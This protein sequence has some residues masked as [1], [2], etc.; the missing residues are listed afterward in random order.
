MR[1]A[2]IFGLVLAGCTGEKTGDD[3]SGGETGTDSADT[4]DSGETGETGNPPECNTDNEECAPG[5]SGCGGEGAN[6]LP[7]SDCIACHSQGGDRE[8][9]NWTIGGT[10]FTDQYGSA[11]GAGVRVTITDATGQSVTLNSSSVGNFYTSQRLTPP[12]TASVETNEGTLTMGAAVDT[13]ACNSCHS[14]DGEAEGKL[15]AP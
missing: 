3:T 7:G 6:M 14:C 10:V 12:F 15:F 11:P 4:A 1:A 5:V 8:A 13:G 2:L 9:P